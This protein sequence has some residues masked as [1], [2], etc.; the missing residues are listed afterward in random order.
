MKVQR[1]KKFF[2]LPKDPLEDL[3]T[4]DPTMDC[5]RHGA[6][7]VHYG[8]LSTLT[9]TNSQR[10]LAGATPSAWR[11]ARE[12]RE[13]SVF[14]VTRE[15]PSVVPPAEY[16]REKVSG[17]HNDALDFSWDGISPS[18]SD[19]GYITL[20][21][22][23]VL[24]LE[25]K[26]VSGEKQVPCLLRLENIRQW[27]LRRNISVRMLLGIHND[28]L[29]WSWDGISPSESDSG[30]ITCAWLELTSQKESYSRYFPSTHCFVE[31]LR[32][33]ITKKKM[34]DV[35]FSTLE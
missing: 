33:T 10:G 1:R 5:V 32:R 21:W 17:I 30:Y 3:I 28:A 26:P 13:S 22:I 7:L 2:R 16:L 15:D 20:R 31:L 9:C 34:S 8:N 18:E 11:E 19:S 14:A 25:E 29:D 23:G 24:Q 12:W 6:D 35:L 27:F 4:H